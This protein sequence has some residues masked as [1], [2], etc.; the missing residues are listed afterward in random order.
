MAVLRIIFTVLGVSAK[1]LECQIRVFGGG[2]GLAFATVGVW[3]MV[4][5]YED[6]VNPQDA[7]A[8]GLMLALFGAG[9]FAGV[10][11][12]SVAQPIFLWYK[13]RVGLRTDQIHRP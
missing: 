3:T 4:G 10:I 9:I 5:S 2:I 13:A 6:P 8:V 11:I 1:V 7:F 12:F